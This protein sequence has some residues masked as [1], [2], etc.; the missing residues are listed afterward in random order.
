MASVIV[1]HEDD[2]VTEA[3]TDADVLIFVPPPTRSA[4]Q[5]D[6]DVGFV[7]FDKPEP[8]LVEETPE[9]ELVVFTDPT[10]TIAM[11]QHGED[12]LVIYSGGPPGPPGPGSGYYTHNQT[13]PASEWLIHHDLGWLPNISLLIGNE[14]VFA[15]TSHI[16][17]TLA[18][19]EFPSPQ[20]GKAVC[21]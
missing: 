12:V 1:F 3:V 2:L 13:I 16:S 17:T 9:P 7:V 4:T 11:D 5:T 10:E 15:S 14:V 21:S 6:P 8:V 20:T 19:V 18:R